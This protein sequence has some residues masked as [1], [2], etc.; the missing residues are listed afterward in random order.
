MNMACVNGCTTVDYGACVMKVCQGILRKRVWPVPVQWMAVIRI[1]QL[2][3]DADAVIDPEWEW[4]Y[5]G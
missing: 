2:W 1:V 4:Q 3:K 5:A